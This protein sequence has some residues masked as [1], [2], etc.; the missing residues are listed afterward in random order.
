MGRP[1]Q[2]T[3]A[4]SQ[5][6][7]GRNGLAAILLIA[8]MSFP[9]QFEQIS[10]GMPISAISQWRETYCRHKSQKRFTAG[11]AGKLSDKNVNWL[12]A[13]SFLQWAPYV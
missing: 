6:A 2:M 9:L 4:G 1:L 13:I 8:G 10:S 7:D 12:S 5:S 3:D 11:N